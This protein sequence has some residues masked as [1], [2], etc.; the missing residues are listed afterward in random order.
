MILKLLDD[1]KRWHLYDDI[2]NFDF[3]VM[4]ING[5]KK[6]HYSCM[7]RRGFDFNGSIKISCIY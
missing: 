1:S 5:E 3:K 7:R 4:E 2:I 6:V